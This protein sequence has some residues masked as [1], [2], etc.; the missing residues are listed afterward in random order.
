M[1]KPEG[2]PRVG[3]QNAPIPGN[4][5]QQ[6]GQPS[7]RTLCWAVLFLGCDMADA[8][9]RRR[10][11]QATQNRMIGVS[12]AV[13][14]WPTARAHTRRSARLGLRRQNALSAIPG[15]RRRLN[16][17]RTSAA[18]YTPPALRGDRARTVGPASPGAGRDLGRVRVWRRFGTARSDL[19]ERPGHPG[20][21][22]AGGERSG[23]GGEPGAARRNATRAAGM[24]SCSRASR[25]SARASASVGRFR[26][27][28]RGHSRA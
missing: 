14:S 26:S 19:A 24:R 5:R 20:L 28:A 9:D 8:G 10:P 27:T 13:S 3:R 18:Q 15:F 11:D 7:T 1:A 6:R 25:A 2:A 12:A 16:G 17:Q 21:L 22:S 23:A 4:R